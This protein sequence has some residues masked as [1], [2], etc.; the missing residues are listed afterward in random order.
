M[1]GASET[2]PTDAPSDSSP[3]EPWWKRAPAGP[4]PKWASPTA[5]RRAQRLRT[6]LPARLTARG[7]AAAGSENGTPEPG[8]ARLELPPEV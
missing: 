2:P 3:A 7:G 6:V 8:A 1:M 4:P 5:V